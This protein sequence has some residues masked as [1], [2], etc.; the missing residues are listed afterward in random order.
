MPVMFCN[1][2]G[3]IHGSQ[4]VVYLSITDNAKEKET[5][6]DEPLGSNTNLTFTF[7]NVWIKI[8]YWINTVD[9]Q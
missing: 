5:R 1:N 3:F 6:P 7:C 9:S 4:E 2:V 8:I